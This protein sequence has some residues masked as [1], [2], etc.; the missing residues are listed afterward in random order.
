[1]N[2]YV[3]EATKMSPFFVNKGFNPRMSFKQAKINLNA[4]V[5]DI[6]NFIKILLDHCYAE[7]IWTQARTIDAVNRN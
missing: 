2:N 6:L 5:E 4:Y 7:L 3:L 1:M